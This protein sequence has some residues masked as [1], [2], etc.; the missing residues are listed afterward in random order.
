MASETSVGELTPKFTPGLL[1]S[2]AVVTTTLPVAA[3]AGTVTAMLVSLQLWTIAPIPL[4]V[5]PPKPWDA[6]NPLPMIVT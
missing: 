5:T 6:P 2:P 4:K 3:P 1:R